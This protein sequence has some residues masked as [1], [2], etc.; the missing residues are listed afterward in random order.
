MPSGLL[1][2]FQPTSHS[3][4]GL[5]GVDQMMWGGVRLVRRADGTVCQKAPGSKPGTLEG[6][7]LNRIP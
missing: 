3:D 2:S 7:H 6:L 4:G 1:R 5:R